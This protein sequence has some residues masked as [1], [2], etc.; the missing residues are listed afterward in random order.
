MIASNIGHGTTAAISARNTSRFVRFF[1]LAKSSDA[2]LNCASMP[3]SS[4]QRSQFAMF[5]TVDQRF[6]RSDHRALLSEGGSAGRPTAV[7]DR[8]DVAHLLLAAMVLP[9]RSG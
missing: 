7:P 4:N 5:R 8:R 6:P 9:V 3:C 2:K 1:L